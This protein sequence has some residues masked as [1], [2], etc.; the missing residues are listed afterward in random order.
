MTWKERRQCCGRQAT[1]IPMSQQQQAATVSSNASTTQ[2]LSGGVGA[3]MAAPFAL[4]TS[5]ARGSCSKRRI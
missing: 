3:L 2:C 4:L 5:V 1:D